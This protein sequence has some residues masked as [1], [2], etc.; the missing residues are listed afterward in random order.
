MEIFGY[1]VSTIKTGVAGSSS[2]SKEEV[3]AILRHEFGLHD[4]KHPSH[5]WDAIAVGV[6][7]LRMMTVAES[8]TKAAG[9]D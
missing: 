7:H 8:E 3:E 9:H 4:V 5:V 6:Y 1:N 2:A